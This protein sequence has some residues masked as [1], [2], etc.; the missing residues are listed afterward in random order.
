[1]RVDPHR[2]GEDASTDGLGPALVPDLA[3]Y[4]RRTL[5]VAVDKLPTGYNLGTGSF[6]L[7]PPHHGGYKLVVGSDYSIS[8]I[9]V[10]DD[11]D[12]QPIPLLAGKAYQVAA[13]NDH[14][15]ELFTDRKGRFAAVGLKPGVWRIELGENAM[16]AYELDVKPGKTLRRLAAPLE[17]LAAKP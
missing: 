1:V 6:D 8:I 2:D 15:V 16:Y 11:R 13:P 7:L 12:G 17:P 4:S 14:P 3:G 5:T 9:G 10:L